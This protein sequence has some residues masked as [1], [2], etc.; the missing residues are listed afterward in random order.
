M[1]IILQTSHTLARTILFLFNNQKEEEE[2]EEKSDK[3]TSCTFIE[4]IAGA[5]RK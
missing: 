2:E 4:N 1:L 3:I 5:K